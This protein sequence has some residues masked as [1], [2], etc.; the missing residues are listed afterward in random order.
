MIINK[1]IL[2]K[3]HVNQLFILQNSKRFN[4]VNCGRQFGKDALIKIISITTALKNKK[5]AIIAPQYRTSLDLW[6]EII[7]ITQK[8]IVKKDHLSRIEFNTGGVIEFWSLINFESIRGKRYNSVIINEAAHFINLKKA[9]TEVIRPTLTAHKGKCWFLSTPKGRNYFK[10]LTEMNEK[11]NWSCFHF[12]SYDNP[13]IDSREIDDA[14]KNISDQAFRQEYLAEFVDG[15]ECM[16]KQEYIRKFYDIPENLNIFMGVDLAMS[17]KEKSDYTAIVVLGRQKETNNIYILDVYR[18]KATFNEILSKI[19]FFANKWKPEK[20]GIESVQGQAYIAQEMI[21]TSTYNI[22]QIHPDKDKI[23]RFNTILSRYEQGLVYHKN[24]LI[25]D[26]E[27]ELMEFPIGSHDDMIDATV[28]AF[29]MSTKKLLT[30][31][32]WL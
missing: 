15:L 6:N 12:T 20:I 28:H 5:V 26:F 21:R 27:H 2:Q 25:S 22:E 7:E 14:K 4:V 3:P 17:T 18:T 16:M 9:W 8:T 31:Q 19:N 10:E 24:D 13:K 32:C 23:T 30:A 11:S 29:L 1:I